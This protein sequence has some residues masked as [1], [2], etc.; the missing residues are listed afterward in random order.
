M[1]HQCAWS[2]ERH[3]LSQTL[4]KLWVSVWP[5][6]GMRSMLK[7]IG[8]LRSLL[9]FL[10]KGKSWLALLSFFLTSLLECMVDI[11][12]WKERPKNSEM[13]ETEQMPVAAYLHLAFCGEN[14]AL[15][16]SVTL[17][18]VFCNWQPN[19]F[20]IY[21]NIVSEWGFVYQRIH[22]V[23]YKQL[24]PKKNN[25][26][27][28]PKKRIRCKDLNTNYSPQAMISFK[29]KLFTTGNY[30]CI[31]KIILNHYFNWWKI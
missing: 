7:D 19:T 11:R 31:Q 28:W 15:F 18:L 25:P 1:R 6:L 12:C 5:V 2:Q 13:L 22:H 4:Q 10:I 27:L 30:F 26:F 9:L 24:K 17:R 16:V 20:L 3:L 21:T 23:Q 14:R 29:Y 8:E